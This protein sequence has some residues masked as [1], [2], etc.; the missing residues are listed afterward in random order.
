MISAQDRAIAI[1]LIEEATV[2][3]AR[4]HNACEVIGIS[5]R[6]LFRWRSN[7]APNEDQRPHAK[8]PMPHNKLT[9]DEQA[10]VIEIVN[11]PEFKSLP[12]SQIVPRLAD[13][14]LYI[15]SESTMYRVLKQ[16]NM[17]HHR[18]KAKKPSNR[19][20]S[21]HSADGP[22]QVWMWDITYLP[23]DVK[24]FYYYLYMIVDLFSRKIVGWEVWP[25]ESAENASIL[26]RRAIMAERRTLSGVPLV[27]HS[28]NGSPMKGA[29]LLETL[30][31]L[32]IIPSRSRARV[33]N[34]NAYAE[35]VFKTCKYRPGFPTKGFA[36][37][38]AAREWVLEFVTW[39]NQEHRHS[40]LN[41]L[42][43]KQRH[44][45][46]SESVFS[47]RKEVYEAAKKAHPERWSGSTRN[48]EL[49]ER[50]WLNPERISPKSEE[51]EKLS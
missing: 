16:H 41:F 5:H 32:G 9:D 46:Q 40:G 44:D 34:D 4:E 1:Q 28:D 24:G 50:V 18:G 43:P 15:A 14:G 19:P 17:Q 33:S 36:S 37:I 47:R 3:G 22:N 38:V 31:Q 7:K 49:E 20:V 26:V 13:K 10:K 8:R 45:G 51:E 39:Y 23:A 25:V 6:T 21:T 35:S 30:Y 11:Q 29:S 42:T 27:L 2:N 12:P 48:W